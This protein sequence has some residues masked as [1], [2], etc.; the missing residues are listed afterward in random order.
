MKKTSHI[1]F[2]EKK[3]IVCKNCLENHLNIIF[4]NRAN[5]FKQDKFIGFE[6]YSRPIHIFQNYYIN[7]YEIIELLESLNIINLISK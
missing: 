3:F 6:Y 2:I 1:F 7:D 5:A 4:N